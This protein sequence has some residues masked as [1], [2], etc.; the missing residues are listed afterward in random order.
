M[1]A[2]HLHNLPHS[3][4]AGALKQPLFQVEGVH[5]FQIERQADETPFASGR[6]QAAQ[7]ELAKAEDLLDDS[8][9][10]FDG[11]FAQTINCLADCGLEFVSHLND[12]TCLV[13]G[14]L[15]LLLEKGVP[16][17]MMGFASSG[18]IGFNAKILAI[19][20]VGFREVAIVHRHR[21]GSS[22]FHRHRFQGR[23]SFLFIVGMIRESMRHDQQALLIGGHLHI[24][25]L[26]KASIGAVLHTAPAVGAGVM[27]ESGSVKLY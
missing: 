13:C 2:D 3:R 22:D 7:G 25:V 27:R 10:R 20:D 18:D 12:G 11:A 1:I 8:D 24:V 5:T 23:Q 6:R 17:E 9:H 4:L 16:V 19:L 21:L 15:R 26:V 14:W